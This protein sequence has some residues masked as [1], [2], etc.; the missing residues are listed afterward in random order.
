MWSGTTSVSAALLWEPLRSSVRWNEYW[1]ANPG[2]VVSCQLSV[3]SGQLS[4]ESSPTTAHFQRFAEWIPAL[5]QAQG[6]F[7]AGVTRF[8]K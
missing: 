6:K 3:V 7:F 5:R 4:R 8:R 1:H 2:E